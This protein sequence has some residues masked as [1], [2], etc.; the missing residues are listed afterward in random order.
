MSLTVGTRDLVVEGG[1]VGEARDISNRQVVIRQSFVGPLMGAHVATGSTRI[2][3]PDQT[4]PGQTPCMLPK[5]WV[6]P[7]KKH[8]QVAVLQ[9]QQTGTRRSCCGALGTAETIDQ[10]LEESCHAGKLSRLLGRVW[11]LAW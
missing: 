7:I 11:D 2:E 4:R 5:S 10:T 6:D 3:S 1:V 9:Y 8:H